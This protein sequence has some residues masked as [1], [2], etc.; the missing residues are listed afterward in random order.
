MNFWTVLARLGE[1]QIL[2]PALAAVSAWLAWRVAVPR[3]AAWWIGLIGVAALLTTATKLAFIGW[4]LG[5][6]PLD[7]TGVSGH[8]MFAA[9][10]LP[11]LAFA[12][13]PAQRVPALAAA[14]A[15]AAVIAVSRLET[16]AHS[17][18]EVAVGFVLGAAASALALRLGTLP[19]QPLPKAVLIGLLAW[20]AAT[21]AAA[22][23]SRTHG[24]VTALAL[25]MSGRSAPYTREAMF[26][27]WQ[28]RRMAEQARRLPAPP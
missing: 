12:A 4:G 26:Q 7:F 22:P 21:P 20:M 5:Y 3:T 11:L 2:L 9:A 1:A 13:L 23:P 6:A 18:S 19:S 16:G 24:W 15:L 10:V 28:A 17:L 27:E 25:T 8:A 14:Y